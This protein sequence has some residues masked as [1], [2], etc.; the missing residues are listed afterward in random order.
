VLVG[1]MLRTRDAAAFA[2]LLEG[3]PRSEAGATAPAHGLYLE[4]VRY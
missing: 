4:S 3:R 2:D 1:T